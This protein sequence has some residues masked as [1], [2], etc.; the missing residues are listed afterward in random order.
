MLQKLGCEKNKFVI[1]ESN[2][3]FNMC[4]KDINKVLQCYKTYH[5][6]EDL[7]SSNI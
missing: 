4:I 6:E 3:M 7:L 1:Y 2:M 5:V